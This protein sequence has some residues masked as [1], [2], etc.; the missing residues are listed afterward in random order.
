MDGRGMRVGS[1]ERVLLRGEVLVLLKA[2]K[3][4]AAAPLCVFRLR[5]DDRIFS[6]SPKR[7]YL[8]CPAGRSRLAADAQLL[9]RPSKLR[10]AGY[11]RQ[12]VDLP[13]LVGFADLMARPSH[14][15]HAIRAENPFCSFPLD[16]LSRGG[17]KVQTQMTLCGG[18]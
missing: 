12:I 15:A 11:A 5:G 3:G 9:I 7:K 6:V 10:C 2:P 4:F 18:Q 17:K 14:R 16:A 1:S 8:S 13:S